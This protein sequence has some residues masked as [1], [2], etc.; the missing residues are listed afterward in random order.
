[1]KSSP[2]YQFIAALLVVG[3]LTA[4][5]AEKNTSLSRAYHNLTARYN[6]YFNGYESFEKGCRKI[7]TSFTDDF[8]NIIPVFKYGGKDIPSIVGGDMDR[9]IKKCSKLITMHS[10]TAKP[11]VKGSK[12]LTDKQREFFNK[13]EYNVFVDDAYLLM[14]KAHFYRHEYPM[15]Q[16]IFIL[17]LNDYKNQ[18][19]TYET[20]LW[21]A[22]LYDETGQ[23]KNAAEILNALENNNRIPKRLIPGLYATLADHHLKQQ[24]YLHAAGYLEKAA[25][26]EKSKKKR[27]R[28]YFILAQLY[29]KTGDL[30]KASDYYSLVIKMNPIYDMAFNARINRALAY[31]QGFGGESEI[32]NELIKMLRDDKNIDY[33]DQVYFA[34]GNLAAKAGNADKAVEYYKKSLEVNKG[35]DRQKS[36][37]YLTLANYYYGIPDYS[38]AQ[39]YYDSTLTLIDPDFPGYDEMFTKSRSLTQLVEQLNTVKLED[40]VQR[41]AALPKDELYARID[42]M[43]VQERTNE[44]LERQRQRDQQLDQQFSNEVTVQNYLRQQNTPEGAK[45]YFYNDAAK[46]MGY[47]EFRLKWGNRKL[48]DHWQRANKAMATFTTAAGTEEAEAAATDNNGQEK[49]A[50]KM[51]RDYYLVNVPLSD[52]AMNASN[53]R[54]EQALY[55]M[56]L[57]Y[58]NDLRDYEKAT[59]AFKE[60]I[61]R[62][63]DSEYQLSAL[64]NLYTL[65]KDQN[66]EAMAD[67][68]KN[69]ISSRFPE[70]T[71]AKL[72]TNP[73]YIKEMEAAEMQVQQYYEE[74]YEQ[75]RKGNYNEVITRAGYAMRNFSGNPSIPQ[76]NYLSILAMANNTD[77]KIFRDSL[78]SLIQKYPGSDVAADAKN[79]ITYMDTE[80]PEYKEAAELTLSKTLYQQAATGEHQFAFIADRKSDYNQLIFNIINFN[81]DA[82][83]S[84][85]LRVDRIELNN[86]QFLIV[87]K[88]FTDRETA[89][90]Y[91]IAIKNNQDILNDVSGT[92][93]VPVIISTANLN[94]LVRDK[95]AERYMKFFLENYL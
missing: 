64:F 26:N 62:F 88:P 23:Y 11:R 30:K 77:R 73:D 94:I 65:A 18:P 48:E 20:R 68:Y 19:I 67:F 95:S 83:D 33:Q 92:R 29:E 43:I 2:A 4:C 74:T 12:N 41:L 9:T 85:N 45:W 59:N 40:S 86:T 87:V 6:V 39:A 16:E 1:L 44:E 24:E 90:Q 66:N 71:Y 91:Y 53:R 93:P 56:G 50:S 61:R 17:I 42:A 5:S 27:T 82:F 75:Y 55:Q 34:L 47:R 8:S 7:E 76:F 72:L 69:N 28:Y 79:L 80:H 70:S 3:L 21:L 15:A 57:L 46:S 81:L 49:P 37:T 52:S 51:S 60:L 78:A 35:N 58:K 13:K 38:N 25:A 63:P 31:Q 84:L 36:R 32:E 89:M 10:I 14:G 54:I 22:R